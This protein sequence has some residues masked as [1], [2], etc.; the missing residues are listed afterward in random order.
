MAGRRE[1]GGSKEGWRPIAAAFAV[2]ALLIHV[3]MPM[4]AIAAPSADGPTVICTLHGAETL[5]G[6]APAKGTPAGACH[7][8]CLVAAAVALAPPPAVLTAPGAY[9]R[10]GL[11]PAP[12]V[13]LALAR[14]PPRPPGQGPPTA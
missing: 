4:A 14:A 2:F 1:A 3:F 6:Q 9:E 5:P 12:Q 10:L 7:Q 11:T 8:C 13:R